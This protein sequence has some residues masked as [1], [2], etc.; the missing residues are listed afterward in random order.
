MA[1]SGRSDLASN[2]DQA[3]NVVILEADNVVVVRSI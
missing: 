2:L 1:A 3:L